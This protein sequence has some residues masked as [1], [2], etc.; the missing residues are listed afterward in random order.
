AKL[1][2]LDL[3]MAYH[4]RAQ[5]ESLIPPAQ[6]RMLEF[7]EQHSGCTQADVAEEMQVSPASVAQSIKRMEA[8][9]FVEKNV[10]EDNL[11]ANSLRITEAGSEAAKNCRLVFDG[12]EAK[13]LSGFSDEERENFSEALLRV[14][15]NLESGDTG[16]MNNMELSKLLNSEHKQPKG[17]TK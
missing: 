3:L 14:I 17:D 15:A 2:R 4:L 1:H 8:A 5:D 12:L 7:I 10:R 11:R 13:M 6:M 9:G 16:A